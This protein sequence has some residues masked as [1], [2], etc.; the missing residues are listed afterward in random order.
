RNYGVKSRDARIAT[1]HDVIGR[2]TSNRATLSDYRNDV[3][4]T[5]FSQRRRILALFPRYA[6]HFVCPRR[7][8]S[9]M[10]FLDH[11]FYAT[12]FLHIDHPIGGL[13]TLI[14]HHLRWRFDRRFRELIA[15]MRRIPHAQPNV[16]RDLDACSVCLWAKKLSEWFSSAVGPNPI[17]DGQRTI[18]ERG[19]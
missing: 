7:S 14:R 8:L 13:P 10:R 5:K 15:G 16:L 17:L 12:R 6:A 2:I 1:D 11:S 9:Y 19:R 4:G 18:G 3:I